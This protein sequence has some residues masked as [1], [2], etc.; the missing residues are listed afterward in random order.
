MKKYKQIEELK[1]NMENLGYLKCAVFENYEPV[2]EFM[3]DKEITNLGISKKEIW[4]EVY[5][6]KPSQKDPNNYAVD[7]NFSIFMNNENLKQLFLDPYF[8]DRFVN[9]NEYTIDDFKPKVSKE[10]LEME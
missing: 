7:E 8:K 9:M 10:E 3:S 2:S 5:C 4:Q 6:W 1:Q